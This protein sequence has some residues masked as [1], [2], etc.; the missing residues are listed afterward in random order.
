[1]KQDFSDE[2]VLPDV[3]RWIKISYKNSDF[4]IKAEILSHEECEGSQ[5]DSCSGFQ[6]TVDKYAE[7]RYDD[8]TLDNMDEAAFN[9]SDW[10][11]I[12]APDKAELKAAE[13]KSFNRSMGGLKCASCGCD[14]KKLSGCSA[15]RTVFYC[16]LTCQRADW[17]AHKNDCKREKVVLRPNRRYPLSAPSAQL[18][19]SQ[20]KAQ[21]EYSRLLQAALA[22]NFTVRHTGSMFFLPEQ[23]GGT[24][25]EN[26]KA[27]VDLDCLES[28]KLIVNNKEFNFKWRGLCSEEHSIPAGKPT[29]CDTFLYMEMVEEN[30]MGDMEEVKQ[31][32]LH[33]MASMEDKAG[34]ET[35]WYMLINFNTF[36]TVAPFHA[37]CHCNS[38]NKEGQMPPKKRKLRSRWDK[39][40][41]RAKANP[42]DVQCMFADTQVGCHNFDKCPFKHDVEVTKSKKTQA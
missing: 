6:N 22:G 4:E 40:F 29:A 3:G 24:T 38:S 14:S 23:S 2:M 15:C 27:G 26:P 20:A 7:I 19:A 18:A 32:G 10:S 31:G 34:T 12:N 35:F 5:W 37:P 25:V 9:R 28:Y 1:M 21:E 30:V 16:D 39:M 41:L 33:Y 42:H 36:G 13:N 11:Y 17:G 8:G